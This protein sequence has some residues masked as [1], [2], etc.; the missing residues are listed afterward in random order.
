MRAPF[1]SRSPGVRFLVVIG[2]VLLLAAASRIEV[3]MAPVPITLQTFA[4]ILIGM[5][6]GWRWGLATVLVWL[7]AGA[8]GLPVFSGGSG[9]WERFLGPTGGYLAGFALAAAVSGW[10]AEK[11]W[12]GRKPVHAFV[13]ALIGHG[14]C[15]L[16]GAAWLATSVG[17]EDAIRDGLLPFLPGAIL[18]SVAVAVALMLIVLARRR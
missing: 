7:A 2:G 1:K 4:V 10:L 12:D 15:L 18:K 11:G 13:A 16:P 8:A 14:F 3:P 5:A 17:R 9:G 6:L